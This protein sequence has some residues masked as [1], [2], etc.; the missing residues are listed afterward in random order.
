MCPRP[1]ASEAVL[2]SARSSTSLTRRLN[3]LGEVSRPTSAWRHGL[4]VL[5]WCGVREHRPA[6]TPAPVDAREEKY[7]ADEEDQ[8][9]VEEPQLVAEVVPRVADKRH[10]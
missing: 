1:S 4:G 2:L 7:R 6:P 9:R 8:Q 3:A 5:G 10:P